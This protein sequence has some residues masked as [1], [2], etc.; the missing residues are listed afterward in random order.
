MM[1]TGGADP[2]Y[3]DL[4][5]RQ[6]DIISFCTDHVVRNGYPPTLR[7]IG[8]A[9]GLK[10][11]S[12]VAYQVQELQRKGYLSHDGGRPRTTTLR[13]PAEGVAPKVPF[14]PGEHEQVPV[15][16]IGRIAAGGPISAVDLAEEDVHVPAS[17]AGTHEH[18]ALEVVG[19]SMIGKAIINGDRVVVRTDCEVRNGDTVVARFVSDT[20]PEGEATLK[21][22]KRVGGHVWLMPENPDYE[23]ILG[24]RATIVGKV[25][26]VSRMLC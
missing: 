3:P 22:F 5:R 18:F 7:E 17:I 19:D 9:V 24:D 21:T 2:R 12:S 8:A 26:Y 23:P 1:R 10:S 15:Q 13:L 14:G 4:S 16:V 20:S 6:Q 25:V 11:P